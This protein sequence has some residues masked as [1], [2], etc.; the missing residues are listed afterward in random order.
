[1]LSR[2]SRR[3]AII[4]EARM[5]VWETTPLPIQGRGT[6]LVLAAGT[7]DLP[8]AMEALSHG[9]GH[10]Q[11]GGERSSMS[12]SPASTGCFGTAS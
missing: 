7:S 8:V 1:M 6:I 11:P 5:L 2:V 3:R 4:A 10:G 12:G 9:P